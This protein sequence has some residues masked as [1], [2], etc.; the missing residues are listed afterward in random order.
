VEHGKATSF[1]ATASVVDEAASSVS[2]YSP[3]VINRLASA[4]LK[5]G[6]YGAILAVFVVGA[7]YATL[8]AIKGGKAIAAMIET[9]K[10][11]NLSKH[12]QELAS[13]C[14]HFLEPLKRLL[15][16]GPSTTIKADTFH[17][18]ALLRDG[19]VRSD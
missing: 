9:S 5:A 1:K 18:N 19:E 11:T 2:T 12:Q 17:I 8:G 15:Q 3:A 14:E 7:G 13:Y 6:P 4:S 16:L 10:A